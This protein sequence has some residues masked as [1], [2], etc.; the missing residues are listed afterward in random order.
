M[1][2]DKML[3]LVINMKSSLGQGDSWHLLHLTCFQNPKTFHPSPLDRISPRHKPPES[4][5][6]GELL[7]ASYRFRITLA[8]L[9][10]EV[11]HRHFGFMVQKSADHHW[12]PPGFLGKRV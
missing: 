2:A 7:F 10:P 1:S 12:L 9:H 4:A 6:E 5:V 8:F 11:Q 3:S